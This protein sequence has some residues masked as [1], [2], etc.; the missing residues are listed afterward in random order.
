MMKG[1]A[2]PRAINAAEIPVEVVLC[3]AGNHMAESSGAPPIAT[4]PANPFAI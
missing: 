2:F 4:G 1:S 3:S